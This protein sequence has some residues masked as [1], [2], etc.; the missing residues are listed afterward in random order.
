[1]A[2]VWTRTTA[3]ASALQDS[4]GGAASAATSSL[5]YIKFTV[6]APVTTM[7]HLPTE[8]LRD[9]HCAE[10]PTERQAGTIDHATDDTG[11]RAPE[12]QIATRVSAYKVRG[13]LAA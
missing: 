5:V 3:G 1:M 10:A 12:N 7:L 9:H 8:A 11:D 4:V 2:P 13:D 6:S